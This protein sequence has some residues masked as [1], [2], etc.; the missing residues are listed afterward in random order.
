MSKIGFGGSCHWCTEAIFLS[1]KG[2]LQ[3]DQ[4]WIASNGDA[5][6]FS[7]AVIVAYD[8]DIISLPMLIAVHLYTHSCT[9]RHSMRAKYRSAIYIFDDDQEM[10]AKAAI[11]QLQ[12]EF[13]KT[14][15]TTVIP[16]QSFKLNDEQYLNYYYKDSAKPFCRNIVN[17]KLKDLLKRFPEL[18]DQKKLALL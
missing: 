14:I 4:G 17:P 2:V 6:S 11:A 15:V 9:S 5:S 7:E 13:T 12:K 16:F 8:E 3:V 1:L 10:I 18:T